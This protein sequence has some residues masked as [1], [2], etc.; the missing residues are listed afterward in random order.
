MRTQ[1]VL[2]TL[3]LVVVYGT[4]LASAVLAVVRR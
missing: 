3:T 4:L 2:F 1:R